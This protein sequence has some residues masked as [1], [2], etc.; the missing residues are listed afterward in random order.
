MAIH[1]LPAPLPQPAPFISGKVSRCSQR[2]GQS[3]GTVAATTGSTCASPSPRQTEQGHRK[4][5]RGESDRDSW[6]ESYKAAHHRQLCP[7]AWPGFPWTTRA[8][9]TEQMLRYWEIAREEFVGSAAVATGTTALGVGPGE[10]IHLWPG[11]RGSC[12]NF[13][14]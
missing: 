10:A 5:S 9:L 12:R 14:K 1:F 6:Q 8:C 2:R 3:S 13:V 11:V 7:K 4:D